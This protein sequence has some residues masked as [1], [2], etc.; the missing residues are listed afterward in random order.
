MPA[1]LHAAVQAIFCA[2]GMTAPDAGLLAATLVAAD[3]RGIHS[4][5]TL[6]V[7]D[8]VGKLTAG[9]VD[10]R[11]RPFVVHEAGNGIVV[12]GGN[13][14]GQIASEFAMRAAIGKAAVDGVALAAVRHSNHCGAMDHWAMM[15][16]AHDMIGIATTNALPT[17]APWGGVEKIVG[18][19]PL[20][21]A[22]PAAEEAPV[23]LDVAFGATAHGKIRV[24][25]QKGHPIPEGWAFD[26]DGRPTTDPAVALE[27]L[28]QPI[29]G[30]KGVGIAI[31][32]GMLS[33]LLSGASYGT[34]LGNMEEGP[35][36]GQDGHVFIAINIASFLPVASFKERADAISR[37]IRLSRRRDGVDRLYPPGLM[38]AEFARRYAV[39]GIPLNQET[40]AGILT[41]AARL[42]VELPSLI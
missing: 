2:C 37:Q 1:A 21:I 41:S 10:P 32:V 8:Y 9:G 38:E 28:I 16:L 3:Q 5:G 11:G 14:M 35:R 31:V 7:P 22:F 13:A 25:H 12:D 42:G 19:N 39:E 4:H 17:M 6:R 36:P 24:Y 33:T 27:G 40:I 23:V 29:G 15:A 26:R 18:I 20:A 34:E 30:Y